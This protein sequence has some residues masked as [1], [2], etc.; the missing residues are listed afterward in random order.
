MV[1]RTSTAGLDA[2]EVQEISLKR[3]DMRLLFPEPCDGDGDG[4]G[5]GQPS[6]VLPVV[7]ITATSCPVGIF[8]SMS[9][10]IV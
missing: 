7:P 8:N 3:L 2:L 10:T 6:M 1:P 5:D 4:D 9:L